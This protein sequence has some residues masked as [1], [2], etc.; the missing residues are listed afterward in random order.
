[1][2][3]KG[4]AIFEKLMETLGVACSEAENCAIGIV[5]EMARANQAFWSRID[6]GRVFEFISC[7][8]CVTSVRSLAF[9]VLSDCVENWIDGVLVD[10]ILLVF[11][12]LP[13]LMMAL[14]EEADSDERFQ[15]VE[16]CGL[17]MTGLFSTNILSHERGLDLDECW[18]S[19]LHEICNRLP[20]D[21]GLEVMGH[22]DPR[23]FRQKTTYE[24]MRTWIGDEMVHGR[25]RF[26]ELVPEYVDFLDRWDGDPDFMINLWELCEDCGLCR[27]S[28]N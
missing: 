8:M 27:S 23:V 21:D 6:V 15:R 11:N 16:Q 20:W 7:G 28:D 24:Y 25:R 2:E 18:I 17:L 22:V 12:T 19:L 13:E 14:M 26:K 10:G 3:K 9:G 1:M 4:C 5:L